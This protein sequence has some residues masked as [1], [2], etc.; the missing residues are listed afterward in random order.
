MT[1]ICAQKKKLFFLLTMLLLL[2]AF[3]YAHVNSLLSATDTNSTL[4]ATD[5]N[6]TLPG[7]DEVTIVFAD[8]TFYQQF[9]YLQFVE[10]GESLGLSEEEFYTRCAW[11]MFPVNKY[12]LP[13]QSPTLRELRQIVLPRIAKDSLYVAGMM[14]RGAASPEGPYENNR[15]LS[16]RRTD[17]LLTFI[18]QHSDYAA[19]IDADR[20]TLS[21]EVEDYPFLCVMMKQA[22]DS[23]YERVL[24]LCQTYLPDH[25]ADL[26]KELQELDGGKLWERLLKDYFPSLRAARV[27]IF[28]RRQQPILVDAPQVAV[29]PP[30]PPVLPPVNP[31][32]IDTEGHGSVTPFADLVI[33]AR[34]TLPRRELLSVKT[35]LLLDAAYMPGYDR[36]CPIPNVAVEYYPLRGH[37]TYGASFDCPWWRHYDQHKFFEVRNYQLETRYYL[38]PAAAL[39]PLTSHL[40]PL[41]SPHSPLYGGF[42]LQAYVHAGLYEIG[43]NRNKGWK[44]EGFG[45]GIGG[46]Y[47]VP[48]T[49]NGHWRL[50]LGLQMGWFRTQYDPFQYENLINPNYHDDL[51][52]YRWT[53]AAKDFK[54]R[55][56]RFN[57]LGPTRVGITLTYD[58]LYRKRLSPGRLSPGPSLKRLS[59]G[60][61]L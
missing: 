55:Q 17:A 8:T 31:F 54:K 15:M 43:F 20:F 53:G 39:S 36:W 49:R 18:H 26:K 30:V 13:L 51:Y 32:D 60:P 29:L 14:I 38:R 19:S 37:F 16:E 52:Y 4:P 11:V 41:T 10:D 56:Y 33:D 24:Q 5:T 42:Y 46:G 7:T 25:V 57:W 12:S 22:G 23:D 27:I 47:V 44:G 50:E 1:S 21:H 6:N 48:L 40:S 61:S 58:L 34:I 3:S 45:A 59:P 28:L 35:N 9:P 2:P